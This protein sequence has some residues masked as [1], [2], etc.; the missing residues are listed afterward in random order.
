MSWRVHLYC[1]RFD[2]LIQ[3]KSAATHELQIL[4]KKSKSIGVFRVALT[5]KKLSPNGL[6]A[7]VASQL[8]G[9]LLTFSPPI[10]TFN[11]NNGEEWKRR[12]KASVLKVTWIK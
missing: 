9:M 8:F 7:T 2:K 3:F 11:T 6:S 1:E 12:K 10:K 5:K 4:N